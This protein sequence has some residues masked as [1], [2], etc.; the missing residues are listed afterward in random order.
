M[1]CLRGLGISTKLKFLIMKKM[2]RYIPVV[3]VAAILINSC[4]KPGPKQTKYIPKDAYVVFGLNSKNIGDKIGKANISFDSVARI[5]A[6]GDDS[7]A[8]EAINKFNDLKNS[9]IDLD[10]EMFGFMKMGG[11]IMAGQSSSFGFVGVLKDVATFETFIKK[12]NPLAEV[13]KGPNYSYLPLGDD[14]IAGWDDNVVIVAMMHAGTTSPGSYATGEGTLSQQMLTGLFAQKE[15]ESVSSVEGFNDVMKENADMMFFVNSGLSQGS[16]SFLDMTKMS[17]LTKGSYATGTANF[18]DGKIVASFSSHVS[19]AMADIL[20]KYPSKSIDMGALEKYPS[21]I[22]GFMAASFDPQLI[23]AVLKYA[24]MDLLANQTLQ[25]FGVNF[26]LDDVVKAF[27]GD[28]TVITSDFGVEEKTVSDYGGIK[29]PKPITTKKPVFKLLFNAS[30]GDKASYD[31]VVSGLASKGIMVQENGQYVVQG[32]KGMSMKV[33][34]KNL[35]VASDNDVISQYEAGSPGKANLPSDIHDKIKGKAFAM[36]F[37][38][39]K[40]FQI[41]PG[42]PADEAAIDTAKATFRDFVVTG[43]NFDGKLS[44]GAMELRFVN[45]KENSLVTLLRFIISEGKMEQGRL[46]MYR[47]GMREDMI[48]QADSIPPPPPPSK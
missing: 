23:I 10:Q 33:T 43:D 7:S 13:K 27:K 1:L 22:N 17:D 47:G 39:N 9:G 15:S 37:D 45:D 21:P 24:G 2:M 46:R 48:P 14:Y 38:M 30:I 36:Y 25:Q 41:M 11:S 28:F 31:K 8:T 29:L 40:L 18:E 3:L 16:L 12:K 32:M 4:G 35:Y 20:K 34:D 5:F 19:P 6:H 44:K 42:G 26:T